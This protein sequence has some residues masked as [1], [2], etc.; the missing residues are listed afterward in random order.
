MHLADITV[1]P[2]LGG[3]ELDGHLGFGLDHL[4]NPKGFDFKAMRVIQLIDKGEFDF[5]ALLMGISSLFESERSKLL[6]ILGIFLAALPMAVLTL[7]MFA[8]E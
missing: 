3:S 2:G 6:G 4:F 5:I 8:P 7:M 1:Y